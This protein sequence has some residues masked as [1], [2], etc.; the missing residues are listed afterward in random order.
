ML[1]F[2]VK[3]GEWF[4]IGRH[5]VTYDQPTSTFQFKLFSVN[6]STGA[7]VTIPVSGYRV[8]IHCLSIGVYAKLGFRLFSSSGNE[9][10][11]EHVKRREVRFGHRMAGSGGLV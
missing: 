9:V 3:S 2:S 4:A 11:A 7:V 8:D 10:A 1:R 6:V 5:V